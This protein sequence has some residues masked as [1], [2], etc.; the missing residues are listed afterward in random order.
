MPKSLYR[1]SFVL[2]ILFLVYLLFSKPQTTKSMSLTPAIVKK[3]IIAAFAADSLALGAHWVYDSDVIK[4]Q[5]GDKIKD[6]NAPNLNDYHKGKG[7][8]DFTQYGDQA[9]ILLESLGK[10]K[11]YN[12]EK[13]LQHWA[14]SMEKYQGYM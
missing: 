14:E 6:L 2:L 4:N 8:G 5:L 12:Q 11:S 3:A 7:A 13:F 9:F 1:Y 10:D